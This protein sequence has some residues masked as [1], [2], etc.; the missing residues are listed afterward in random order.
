MRPSWTDIT[1]FGLLLFFAL[2]MA[3]GW[4]SGDWALGWSALGAIGTIVTGGFAWRIAHVQ[5]KNSLLSIDRRRE[6]ARG[7]LQEAIRKTE[8]LLMRMIRGLEEEAQDALNSPSSAMV[9]TSGDKFLN[10]L[11]NYKDWPNY[12]LSFDKKEFLTDSELSFL[13]GIHELIIKIRSSNSIRILQINELASSKKAR[14][15]FYQFALE[16]KGAALW[17]EGNEF[18]G[19]YNSSLVTACDLQLEALKDAGI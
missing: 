13:H 16:I 18:G 15:L 2:V 6:R 1:A 4:P 14:S 11:F 7:D 9:Y 19:R 5:F 17:L 3:N 12:D 8:L 10:I